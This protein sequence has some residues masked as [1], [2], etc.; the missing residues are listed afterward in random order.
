[1][2]NSIKK[3]GNGWLVDGNK[4]VPNDERNTDC[5][6]VLAYLEEGGIVEDE[7]TLEEIEAQA[8]A[9]RLADLRSTDADMA[10]I[11]EDLYNFAVDGT[12]LPQA[13]KDKIANRKA[14]REVL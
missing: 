1:M 13:A 2:I 6:E 11:V 14:K 8:A 7:F 4:S 3:Q 10:R 5:Q 12:P 9:Q